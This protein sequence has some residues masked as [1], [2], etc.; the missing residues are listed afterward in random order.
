MDYGFSIFAA[1]NVY[2]NAKQSIIFFG[3]ALRNFGILMLDNFGIIGWT[4]FAIGNVRVLFQKKFRKLWILMIINILVFA[5][6]LHTNQY[7]GIP[8]LK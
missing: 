6:F 2:I 5:K 7:K 1:D 4:F 8:S 3:Y